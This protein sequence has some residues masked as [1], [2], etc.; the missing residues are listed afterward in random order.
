MQQFNLNGVITHIEGVKYHTRKSDGKQIATQRILLRQHC[1]DKFEQPMQVS[2]T[3]NAINQL[4]EIT[5]GENVT[6]T[7]TLSTRYRNNY[8]NTF[9]NVHNIAVTA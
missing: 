4:E 6:I 2:L 8:P 7:F 9:F 5:I 3:D 1:N